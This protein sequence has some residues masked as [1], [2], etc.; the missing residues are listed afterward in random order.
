MDKRLLDIL[1][2]PVS[3][4]PLRPLSAAERDQLNNAIRAGSVDTVAGEK[5]AEPVAEGLITT[6]GQLVYR[7]EDGIPVMSSLTDLIW[8]LVLAAGVASW[9][10]LTRAREIAVRAAMT[11][12]SGRFALTWG[13]SMATTPFKAVR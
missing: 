6:D 10:R 1:C 7:V 8:L 12:D 13:K 5:V 9:Y 3:K 4:R 11:N 2:C